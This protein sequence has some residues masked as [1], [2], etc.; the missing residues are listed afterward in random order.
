MSPLALIVPLARWRGVRG[1]AG[2]GGE[3]S[4]HLHGLFLAQLRQYVK[5]TGGIALEIEAHRRCQED[6]GNNADSLDI[7]VFYKRQYQRHNSSHQ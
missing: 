7:V 5:L 1:E 4:K 2:V 6:G 3:A